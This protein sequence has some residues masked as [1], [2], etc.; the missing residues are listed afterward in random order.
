MATIIV[1]NNFH[2]KVLKVVTTDYIES[3]VVQFLNNYNDNTTIGQIA[4]DMISSLGGEYLDTDSTY[5]KYNQSNQFTKFNINGE[6]S[7]N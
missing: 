6:L 2:E 7:A 1:P 5:V 4:H 3:L